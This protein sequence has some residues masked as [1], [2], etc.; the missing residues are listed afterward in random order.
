M[1]GATAA[2]VLAA[3]GAFPSS[4]PSPRSPARPRGRCSRSLLLGGHWAAAP[5]SLLLGP[6]PSSALRSV[7]DRLLRACTPRQPARHLCVQLPD[8]HAL[9]LIVWKRVAGCFVLSVLYPELSSA[10][11]E[12]RSGPLGLK[13]F[14]RG[15]F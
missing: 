4:G 10:C 13:E 12:E 5:P 3:P 15:S 11:E 6:S 8:L 14:K 2:N 9:M 1:L 7:P